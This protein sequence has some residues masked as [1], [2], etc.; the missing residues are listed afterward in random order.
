MFRKKNHHSH[1][2]HRHK[3][4]NLL[5]HF[6]HEI[7]EGLKNF[8]HKIEKKIENISDEIRQDVKIAAKKIKKKIDLFY[9]VSLFI[10][11]TFSVVLAYFVILVSTT[12]KSF[13]FVTNEIR[14]KL[15]KNYGDAVVFDD[16]Y[17]SFTRYGTLKI[18]VKNLKISNQ[19]VDTK[20]HQFL[21]PQIE[22]EFSLLNLINSSFVPRK[23]KIYD[24][25]IKL[26]D[27][28]NSSPLA[29]NSVAE[30]NPLEVVVGALAQIKG[31]RL[32]TKNFEIENARLIFNSA[33][34]SKEILIKKSQIRTF[35]KN[36]VLYISSLNRLN[37]SDTKNDV[38]LN[39]SC[40]LAQYNAL[41]C[42]LFLVNFVANSIADLHP[43][44]KPLDQIDA[45]LN[46][47][48]SFVID[49]GKLHNFSF[50]ADAKSGNFSFPELFGERLFFS[51][52]SAKGEYDDGLAILNLSEIKSDFMMHND[53]D[54]A[55]LQSATLKT[56]LDM[57]LLISNLKNRQNIRSDFY[58]KLRNAPTNELEKLWPVYLNDNGV[59]Q[60]VIEHINNGI[61]NEA[62]TRF[63]L[64]KQGEKNVLEKID[65]EM[66]FVG[67]DLKYGEDFPKIT[68]IN[69]T[70]KFSLK[71]MKI[72]ISAGN[73]LNSKIYDSKVEIDDFNAPVTMLKIFGKSKG[74]ASDS[75]K[76]AEGSQKFA[77]MVEKYLNG[78]SQNDFNIQIPLDY[79]PSLKHAYIAV[80][81]AISGLKNDYVKGALD[82]ALKKDFASEKFVTSINLT[83]A[84]LNLKDFNIDKNSGEEGILGFDITFP[85]PQKLE[86]S[87]ILL[88]K[89]KRLTSAKKAKFVDAKISGN[90]SVNTAPFAITSVN[91]RNENFGRNSYQLSYGIGKKGLATK[92]AIRGQ[93]LDLAPFIQNKF[94][95]FSSGNNAGDLNTQIAVDTLL[96]ANSKAVRNFYFALKCSGQFC[97]SGAVKGSY[98]KK[99][100]SILL[101]LDK[102][103]E[104][105]FA[106][107]EGQ[108]T[109][110]GYLAEAL[111][112]YNLVSGGN[113]HLKLQHKVVNKKPLLEGVV[114]FS[115]SIT[116]YENTAVKRLATNN[117]FSKI[118]DKIF[119][120]DKTIFD[121]MKLEFALQNNVIDI[122]SFVAN[123]Y[124]IGITA[125]GT[126]DLKNNAYQIKGMIVPGFIVNNLFGIGKIPLLG[127]VVGLLTG[128]EGGGLFG[129]RY[130]YVKK[131][132][133]KEATFETSKV[134]SFVPTTIKN[135]FDLI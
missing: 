38:E 90:V 115:D 15:H 94:A 127:N 119:S 76:H 17:I 132:G 107:L 7:E 11:L 23:I 22:A 109:D 67:L 42:D 135:L 6:G 19:A 32:L 114:N 1:K 39:S 63:S 74:D 34:G 46:A 24:P 58:I 111:G 131:A 65:A 9:K 88:R 89:K 43:E 118:R 81:S 33:E 77:A 101:H 71:D 52:F 25:E 78:N 98:S 110:L 45:M 13:S 69:G 93:I 124:K 72:A 14:E 123:N 80:N 41:K 120:E 106:R 117:L 61:I 27:L 83:G 70:A 36:D 82:V 5:Q 3:D 128:G 125:K 21:I 62:Y 40:Q 116:I 53:A 29:Q 47:G 54:V 66:S 49:S 57:S 50:K 108:I 134:S 56:H 100:Q 102:K 130:E 35:S 68:A 37:F 75:L 112:I 30:I 97:Y 99:Q 16:A 73:V 12:P 129:I 31:E 10:L 126:V 84:E 85:A 104:E 28:W 2:K 121:S 86:L 122:K 79:E 133:D 26:D 105:N 20:K 48:V 59:R 55:N 87:N 113:A 4:D 8:E 64:A 95:A 44:L 51:D 96:L 92:L 60:W 103:P 18:S 91:L